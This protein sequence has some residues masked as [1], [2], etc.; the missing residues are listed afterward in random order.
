MVCLPRNL[1]G[2]ERRASSSRNIDQQ[3]QCTAGGIGER[4][5]GIPRNAVSSP[6]RHHAC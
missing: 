4:A 6:D 5:A 1:S 2:A 3:A